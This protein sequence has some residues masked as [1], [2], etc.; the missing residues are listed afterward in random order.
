MTEHYPAGPRGGQFM[1]NEEFAD[2]RGIPPS[3]TDLAS[4]ITGRPVTAHDLARL[5]GALPGS[6]VSATLSGKNI[7][8][9][10][11]GPQW[12]A[13]RTLY[14]QPDLH[15]SNDSFYVMREA[16]GQGLGAKMLATQV[17]EALRLSVPRIETMAG[18]QGNGTLKKREGILGYYAWPRLGY[19]GPLTGSQKLTLHAPYDQAQ[20]VAEVLKMPGGKEEWYKHG[21]SINLVF[22]LSQPQTHSLKVLRAYLTEKG[23]SAE[24]VTL[25]PCFDGILSEEDEQILDRVWEKIGSP[26]FYGNPPPADGT[27]DGGP[28][29]DDGNHPYPESKPWG[30]ATQAL[31]RQT[32]GH[33]PPQRDVLRLSGVP[34]DGRAEIL[35]DPEDGFRIKASAPGWH[36]ERRVH[37][38]PDSG[39]L[40]ITNNSQTTHNPGHNLVSR[41]LVTQTRAAQQLG[42]SRIDDPSID[43]HYDMARLGFDGPLTDSHREM[44]PGQYA[45]VDSVMDVLHVPGGP[46]AWMEHGSPYEASF[47]L[48]PGSRSLQILDSYVRERRKSGFMFSGDID[49]P[50]PLLDWEEDQALA[51]VWAHRQMSHPLEVVGEDVT[52]Q[53][54]HVGWVRPL[55]LFDDVIQDL[56][57]D[58]HIPDDLFLAILGDAEPPPL[59]FAFLPRPVIPP[60]IRKPFQGQP[61]LLPT[62]EATPWQSA[63]AAGHEG[64]TDRARATVRQIARLAKAGLTTQQLEGVRGTVAGFPPL[65][66]EY[67]Y[68]SLVRK[69]QK[70][71]SPAD[72]AERLVRAFKNSRYYLGDIGLDDGDILAQIGNDQDSARMA[73]GMV[74]YVK[75]HAAAR[76]EYFQT[77]N[78]ARTSLHQGL[79]A[80]TPPNTVASLPPEQWAHDQVARSFR[81]AMASTKAALAKISSQNDESRDAFCRMFTLPE[82]AV[83]WDVE[84]AGNL[85]TQATDDVGKALAFLRRILSRRP[86]EVGGIKVIVSLATDRPEVRILDKMPPRV[87]RPAEEGTVYELLVRPNSSASHVVHLLGHVLEWALPGVRKNANDFLIARTRGEPATDLV[88]YNP[89]LRAEFGRRDHF[90]RA[91][92]PGLPAYYCGKRN[93]DDTTEVVACG[94]Q[95]LYE[96]PGGFARMDPEYFRFLVLLLQRKL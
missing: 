45:D 31:V 7:T 10:I 35:P 69:A 96:D 68:R 89:S 63:E 80:Y 29:G 21:S 51:R 64:E 85:S 9:H 30:L 78:A 70:P 20:T 87:G 92:G 28:L 4:R 73:K 86:G 34:N 13:V 75:G 27:W 52:D 18:G 39:E 3:A 94:L 71:R 36:A 2:I 1:P 59:S 23:R 12:T 25:P 67:I 81:E 65:E 40:V 53:Q 88:Y 14:S 43:H 16:Q 42:F 72:A 15:I 76:Q 17:K 50:G 24:F 8:I 82:G 79:K 77:S 46:G 19:D 74:E 41:T 95:K 55:T 60:T 37:R 32:L 5:G 61:R 54:P 38:D 11:N 58:R 84:M 22:D 47:D 48:S 49:R 57:L 26:T 56:A 62:G 6:V 93:Q 44:L 83:D 90:D 33:L 91:M 66:A